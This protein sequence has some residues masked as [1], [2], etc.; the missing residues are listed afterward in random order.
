MK[1]GRPQTEQF[2]KGGRIGGEGREGEEEEEEEEE[3]EDDICLRSIQT[4]KFPVFKNLPP[5]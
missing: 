4:L 1:L 2:C 5:Y 3:E